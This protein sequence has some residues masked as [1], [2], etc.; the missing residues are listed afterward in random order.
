MKDTYK[1]LEDIFSQMPTGELNNDVLPMISDIKKERR[2]KNKPT[3][4]QELES[5]LRRI[6]EDEFHIVFYNNGNKIV[7]PYSFDIHIEY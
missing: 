6:Y 7:V 2:E 5:L 4:E 1:M 3:Y